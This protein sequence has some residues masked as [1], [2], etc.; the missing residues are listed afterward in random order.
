MR[1]GPSFLAMAIAGA[2][3]SARPASAQADPP[4]PAHYPPPPPTGIYRRF[5]LS[6][7]VGPGLLVGPGEQ[8]LAISHNV[9]RAGWGVARDLAFFLS[10]EGAR[11]PSVNPATHSNSWLR[12]ETFSLGVQYHVQRTIY[13]RGSAGMGLVGEETATRSFSGGRGVA[14]SGA[15]GIEIAQM[16]RGAVALELAGN[17]TRYAR[18]FWGTTGL[19][20]VVTLF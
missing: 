15:A 20:L 3:L 5:S 16:Y 19:N 17:L 13:L 1:R 12:Q 6:L 10:I 7:A 18:E 9:L 2:L 11:A 8:S 14:L 4:P